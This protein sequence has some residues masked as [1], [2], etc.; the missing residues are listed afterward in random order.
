MTALAILD[1]GY[2]NTDSV[3]LAFRRLGIEA[4]LTG[5]P[6]V[7]ENAERLILPG[8]GA[9]GFAMAK[10][11]EFGLVEPLKRR[12]KPVLGICLGMQLMFDAS[13]EADTAGLGLISG[14]VRAIAPAPGRPV[15]HMGW[16]KIE[17]VAPGIG[18]ADG[19]YLYFAHS[20]ACEDGPAT[21]ARADYGQAIPA[22]IRAGPLWGAQFHPE[23][24]SSA[25][26]SFLAAFLAT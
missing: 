14:R 5:D 23:R 22:A 10:L 19:D 24:S 7:A 3:W 21:A 13:E 9:A 2:G 8:A 20:F 12:T 1:L 4:V 18:L 6:E 11:R 25:G 17:D 26:A 16:S 15:P